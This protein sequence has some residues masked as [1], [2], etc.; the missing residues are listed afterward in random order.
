MA[1]IAFSNL[2]I[3]NWNTVGDCRNQTTWVDG[4]NVPITFR[5]ADGSSIGT[6]EEIK[7][8]GIGGFAVRF[9][10][11]PIAVDKVALNA[12]IVPYSKEMLDKKVAD[13]GST[14]SSPHCPTIAM[15]LLSLGGRS[16]NA[17]PVNLQPTEKE[18]DRVGMGHLPLIKCIGAGNIQ[19]PDGNRVEQ[20]M[21]VFLSSVYPTNNVNVSRL[22]DL[23]NNP[24]TFSGSL[25]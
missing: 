9:T 19:F 14:L 25:M 21:T 12:G 18:T 8:A 6:D 1:V 4:S 22:E 5:R 7:A 13:L 15:K 23:Y 3:L 16:R 2:G 10:A 20:E 24:A 11:I 17:I